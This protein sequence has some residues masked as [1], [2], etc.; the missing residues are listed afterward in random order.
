MTHYN[1]VKKPLLIFVGFAIFIAI[2]TMVLSELL[3]SWRD[4]IIEGKK[5]LT[6]V[7]VE[8]LSIAGKS[9]IDS[10][11]RTDFFYSDSLTKKDIDFLDDRLMKNYRARAASS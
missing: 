9:F 4:D 5:V 6:E 2:L 3:A 10:L 1:F 7:V 11:Y 8:K